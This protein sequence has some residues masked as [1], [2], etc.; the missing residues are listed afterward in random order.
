MATLDVEPTEL[1][2]YAQA[3]ES[4]QRAQRL[5]PGSK[6][7]PLGLWSHECPRLRVPAPVGSDCH[8]TNRQR[9]VAPVLQGGSLTFPRMSQKWA[10]TGSG[11]WAPASFTWR[12]ALKVGPCCVKASMVLP[13]L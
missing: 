5:C 3:E 2:A 10:P 6:L 13:V 12:N 11:L 1:A 8:S 9:G 4:G 7:R